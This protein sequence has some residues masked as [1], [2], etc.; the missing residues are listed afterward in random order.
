M[1]IEQLITGPDAL[2][3]SPQAHRGSFLTAPGSVTDL[4][5]VVLE[6]A[7]GVRFDDVR[8]MPRGATL[9]T[10]GDLCLVALDDEGDP[11]VTAWWPS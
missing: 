11:W 7:E 4:A 10:V 3:A 1:G 9:P 2:A 5:D 8:W 6:Q